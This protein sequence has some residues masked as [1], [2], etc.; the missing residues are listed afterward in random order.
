[1]AR[2]PPTAR[3]RGATPTLVGPPGAR[4]TLAPPRAVAPPGSPDAAMGGES[5]EALGAHDI[6][7]S[8][9]A[10]ASV[11]GQAVDVVT[12]E[13]PATGMWA[14]PYDVDDS[15]QIDFADFATFAR[16]FGASAENPETPFASW[17]DFDGNGMI[18]FDDLAFFD[19]N[20][21]LR[22]D[23]QDLLTFSSAYPTP[24]LALPPA[25]PS[26]ELSQTTL[27]TFSSFGPFHNGRD[28]YDVNNNG[29]TSAL[30]ALLIINALN[31]PTKSHP[32][33]LD[34]SGDGLTTALDALRVINRLNQSWFEQASAT[35]EALSTSNASAEPLW[36]EDDNDSEDE[37]LIEL[38]AADQR[39]F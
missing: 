31:S 21:G 25:T 24:E 20:Q 6:G 2:R 34:V 3:V 23:T 33:F 1:R 18:D 7:L 22:V 15:D 29:D 37:N 30:D 19:A 13:M 4:A 9:S 35:D 17:A 32:Y 39:L 10:S 12:G 38:L 14:V 36:T 5:A 27:E 8:I 26:P 16:V 28:A 11:S